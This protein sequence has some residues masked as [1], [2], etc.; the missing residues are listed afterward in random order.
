LKTSF[1]SLASRRG[2]LEDSPRRPRE[3]KVDIEKEGGISQIGSS[4]IGI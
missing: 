3:Q 1:K 4:S 2:V